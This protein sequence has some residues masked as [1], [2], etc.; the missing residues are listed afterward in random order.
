MKITI[1]IFSWSI[2]INKRI[3]IANLFDTFDPFDTFSAL[4]LQIF[5]VR[6]D[7]NTNDNHYENK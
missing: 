5:K 6:N 4:A 1:L 3:F 2:I 7:E